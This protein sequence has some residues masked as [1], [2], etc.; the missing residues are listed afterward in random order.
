MRLRIHHGAEQ[1]G[2]NCIE[3][4]AAGSSLLLDLGLPLQA[5][6]ALPPVRG[7]LEPDSAL[8]GVVLSHPHLDHYGLLP[9]V[10]ADLP[11][12]LGEGAC[13]LLAA[14]A[15]FTKGAELPQALTPYR[16]GET[17]E[18]GPFRITPYLMD[19]SAFDAHALLI[20][21]EGKRVFYSGDFRGHG[22]K[23]SVFECFVQQPP[24]NIDVLLMEGTTLSRGE[25][26]SLTETNVEAA[27]AQLMADQPGLMLLCFAGQNLDRFVSFL[28]ASMQAGRTL[29]IDAY[30]AALLGA[31]QMRGLS[32]IC[33][34]PALRVFLP[35]NQK[36]MIVSDAR[37]DLI[38][39]YRSKRIFAEELSA[40]PQRFSLVFRAS[41]ARDL[42]GFDLSGA[43]LIYSLWPG[44]LERDRVDLRAWTADHGI[45]FHLLHSSGHA[46]PADLQRMAQALRPKRL[47]PI[48]TNAPDAYAVLY[49]HVEP[50]PN[51]A[52]VEV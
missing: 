47:I 3:L 45:D 7:L 37:F 4:E 49:P 46:H 33:T 48:H 51:G 18:V 52:W 15:P 5:A 50:A 31:A 41:M 12:W 22:R 39:P 35:R 20:E 32:D 28:R 10:R 30:L 23:A 29:V 9:T 17:F 34:H 42:D 16:T 6:P 25:D 13:R 24:D 36:R 27:A 43:G 26:A 19:H 44:Y 2:G 40:E 11:V 8:L 38:N 21:A 1:I 14:A